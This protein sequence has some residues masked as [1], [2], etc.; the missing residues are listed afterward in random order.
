MTP[1][2]CVVMCTA[3]CFYF[4]DLMAVYLEYGNKFMLIMHGQIYIEING[5]LFMFYTHPIPLTLNLTD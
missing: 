2:E 4:V 5:V 3:D 1:R